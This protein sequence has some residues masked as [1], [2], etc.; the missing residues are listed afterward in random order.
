M[1]VSISAS[2]AAA[3][4]SDEFLI[5]RIWWRVMPLILLTYLVAVVDK[6][7]VS[8]AK[9][10]MVH[11][12]GITETAYGMASS[13]FLKYR[14]RSGCIASVRRNGCRASF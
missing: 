7:N 14:V 2:G 6:A 5:R 11:Q 4:D 12:I 8:F 9:L 3:F 1:R 10:Q 13:L